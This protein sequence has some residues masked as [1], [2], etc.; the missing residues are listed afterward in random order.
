MGL[1]DTQDAVLG[2]AAY[3]LAS[4]LQDARVSIPQALEE[5]MLQRYF[6]LRR[7]QEAGFDEEAFRAAYAVMGAQRAA[8]V[9]GIFVRLKLRDGKPGYLRHL[10]RVK[11]LLARNLAHPALGDLR[12]WMEQNL[13]EAITPEKSV[14]G[15]G[16]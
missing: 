1:I 16:A 15:N 9:L 5:M 3:D 6:T 8:K 2:P 11:G 10:P 13:P 4:L 7:Q 14:E 12:A